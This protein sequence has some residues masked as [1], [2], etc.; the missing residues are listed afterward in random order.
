MFLI[1]AVSSFLIP[2]ANFFDAWMRN[3][4][5]SGQ[6]FVTALLA[7]VPFSLVLALFGAGVGLR[8]LRRDF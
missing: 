7:F 4:T 6:G 2:I 3:G 8:S 1:V 5:Y